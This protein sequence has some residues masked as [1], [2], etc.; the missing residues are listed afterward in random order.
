[1]N[2]TVAE[3]NVDE[4]L[5]SGGV[6]LIPDVVDSTGKVRHLGAG[7]GKDRNVYVFDRDNMG[8]F[9][10]SNNGNLYQEVAGG[11]SG[12]SFASPA[13]FNGTLYFGGVGDVIR[14]FKM[15]AG[16]L[17]TSPSSSSA[18][19]F[20]FP[21]TTPSVSANGTGNA[22]LWA[23]ENSSPAVLHAYDANDLVTELYNS[24][25]APS[26]RDQFGAGNK[27]ITPSIGNGKVYV[28]TT[29]SVAVFG[30]LGA[31][32]S[33]IS[34]PTATQGTAPNIILT[35]SNFTAGATVSVSGSGV[36][37]SNT[38]FVS[39]TK[40]TATL[41]VA[42]AA[43]PGAY[44]VSVSEASGGS[45]AVTFTV[46]AKSQTP[47]LSSISPVS[48][49]QGS[50]VTVTLTGTNFTAGATVGVSG[51]GVSAGAVAFVSATQITAPLNIGAAAATGVYNVSV[52]TQAGTSATKPF[53]VTAGSQTPTL[54]SIN[55]ASGTRGSGVNVTLTGTNFTSGSSVSVSGSGVSRSNLVVV[56][57]TEITIRF[58][59]SRRTRAAGAHSVSVATGAG[60]SNAL[61]FTVN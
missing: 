50:S 4:D 31:S 61:Q 53:T 42:A 38:A 47:T 24:N 35:G 26:A 60:T 46:T 15:T 27:F 9:N 25:Q 16:V 40:I 56:N 54:K 12:S 1:M 43:T 14:A 10:P 51:S 17:G 30:L 45:N 48:G 13:W 22:I 59:L 3:S 39:A 8:K 55:P 34:P 23:V 37:V 41:T 2:N 6:L 44:S 49:T 18:A 5:G 21:G 52:T 58:T 11:L 33:S 57:S 28:G 29:N 7:A 19:S 20:A 36:T 32:L